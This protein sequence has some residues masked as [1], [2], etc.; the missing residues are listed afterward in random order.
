[1]I[2]CRWIPKEMEKLFKFFLNEEKQSISQ[3]CENPKCHLARVAKISQTLQKIRTPTLLCEL[4]CKIEKPVQ[5][6]FA[7]N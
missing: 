1:M 7:L 5:T 2:N 3:G 6:H 4:L